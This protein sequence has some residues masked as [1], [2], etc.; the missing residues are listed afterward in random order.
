MLRLFL[1]SGE[2]KLCTGFCDMVMSFLAMGRGLISDKIT[3]SRVIGTLG[4]WV[5]E[6]VF[7]N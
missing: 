5:A 1:S 3:I 4:H 6:T 7:D 2:S